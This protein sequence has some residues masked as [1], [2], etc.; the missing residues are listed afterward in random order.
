MA[1]RRTQCAPRVSIN[2]IVHDD[3]PVNTPVTQLHPA[4]VTRD[5]Q[6]MIE[7]MFPRTPEPTHR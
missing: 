4:E 2:E 1:G 5:D 7:D 6:T 3:Q